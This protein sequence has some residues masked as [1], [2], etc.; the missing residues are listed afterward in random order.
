MNFKV[1]ALL[2]TTCLLLTVEAV[3]LSLQSQLQLA[4]QQLAKLKGD[5]TT[6]NCCN[7]SSIYMFTQ[8]R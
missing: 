7:V 2:A 3:P 6:D 1:V 4:L 5:G 8:T